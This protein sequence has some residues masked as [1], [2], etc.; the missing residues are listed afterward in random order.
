MVSEEEN[1]KELVMGRQ[2]FKSVGSVTNKHT[3]I[4]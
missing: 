1:N 4:L 2:F 3:I